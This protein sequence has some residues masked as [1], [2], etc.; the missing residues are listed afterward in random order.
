V[1]PGYA[2]AEVE[3][4]V[5]MKSDLID[6]FYS[7]RNNLSFLMSGCFVSVESKDGE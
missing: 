4:K 1:T 5:G 7:Q 3:V 2:S 6:L